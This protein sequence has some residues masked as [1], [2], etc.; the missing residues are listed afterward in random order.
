MVDRH[1]VRAGVSA[2]R[3]TDGSVDLEFW[4]AGHAGPERVEHFTANEWVDLVAAVSATGGQATPPQDLVL[5]KD[6]V[7]RLHVARP[8]SKPEE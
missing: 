7:V 2:V 6:A 3:R 5:L 1:R 8:A 4:G